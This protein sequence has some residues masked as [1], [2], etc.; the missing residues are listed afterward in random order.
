M[1]RGNDP[2]ESTWFSADKPHATTLHAAGTKAAG[3]E[4]DERPSSISALLRAVQGYER[5]KIK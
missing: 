5:L 2:D 3:D 1:R 4:P